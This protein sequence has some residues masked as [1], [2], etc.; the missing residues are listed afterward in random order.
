M[1]YIILHLNET[2]KY[3]ERRD[4]VMGKPKKII[5]IMTDTQRKDMINCYGNNGLKTPNLDKLASDG[6]RFENGYTCQPVCGP[7]RSAIFTGTYPHT[8]GTFANNIPLGAST[9][10]IGQR[11]ECNGFSTAFIGKWHLD[12]GDYF[13]YGECPEGW[14][15]NYWYDMRCY[16]EELDDEQR[17]KSRFPETAYEKEFDESFTFA[18]R[19]SDRAIDYLK[20]K[21]DED[22][23]LVVSYD[24]PHHPWL[25][26][27]EYYEM[28]EDY[29]FPLN[30]NI[31]D[32]L[33]GKPEHHKIWA[34]ESEFK[35]RDDV[36]LKNPF[37]FGSNTY[38]D[39]E[40]G[41]VLSAIDEYAEDALIIY[42]SDH[43]ECMESH[44]ITNKGPAMYEEIVNIPFIVKWNG[45]VDSNQVSNQLVSHIDIVPTVLDAAGI[46]GSKILEGKSLLPIFKDIRNTI[47]EQVFIEFTRYE[48]DH[49][50]FGGYQPVRC[51]YDGRFKLAV[52]L[53][54]SDELYDHESDP[55]EMTNLINNPKYADIRNKLHDTVLNWMNETRDPFRGYYWEQR[56]W[57]KDAVEATWDYTSYTRQKEEDWGQKRQLNYSN[58]LVMDE[59]VRHKFSK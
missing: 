29:E 11:M 51:V 10:T 54:T 5:I 8:N 41:R 44:G 42:T 7:A 9:K 58:G 40:I 46:E 53:M 28:Y 27:K 16:L 23:F 17:V 18:H 57:R 47:N 22:L 20:Q 52:N 55:N 19:V 30:E 39:Y 1:I 36:I 50:G 31:F 49:D 25:S 33:E 12:G 15:K 43:G 35:N 26:P 13:G 37:Y 2:I 24:E 45:I 4:S 21:E 14:D 32:T 6:I 3:L 48:I 59:A 56:P 38:V 34:K